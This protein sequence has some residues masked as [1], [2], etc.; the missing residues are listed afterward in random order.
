M[1]K[2]ISENRFSKD[3]VNFPEKHPHESCKLFDTY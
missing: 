2:F 1:A 3:F